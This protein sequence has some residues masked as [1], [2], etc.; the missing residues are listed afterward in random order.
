MKGPTGQLLQLGRKNP[1]GRTSSS[2]VLRQ[3]VAVYI[4]RRTCANGLDTGHQNPS[5]FM[6][7]QR[8]SADGWLTAM[9]VKGQT[10]GSLRRGPG[11]GQQG[12][13]RGSY[14][15]QRAPAPELPFEDASGEDVKETVLDDDF[16]PPQPAKGERPKPD[17]REVLRKQLAWLIGQLA[18]D[19]AKPDE[20][21][22]PPP[23]MNLVFPPA[24]LLEG[25]H[26]LYHRPMRAPY[27]GP[28]GA[29]PLSLRV[30]RL[31]CLLSGTLSDTTAIAFAAS[32]WC[33]SASG[34]FHGEHLGVQNGCWVILGFMALM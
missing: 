30:S 10:Q 29:P 15:Q 21:E 16:T 33:P 26:R 22:G 25:F 20:N 1:G 23:N 14:Q 8:G 11:N 7:G 5:R 18:L 3:C 19:P 32:L 9:S 24:V 28:A 17:G 6:V 2:V 34:S 12:G 4:D 31:F 27:D 13:H